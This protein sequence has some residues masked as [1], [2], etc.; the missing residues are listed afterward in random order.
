M[1]FSFRFALAALAAFSLLAVAPA[2]AAPKKEFKVAWSLYVGWMPWGY[3][4]D[5]GIVKKWADKYGLKIDV[6][7][8]NDYI[9]SINQYTAGS[10]DGVLST[11]MDALAIPSVGGVDTTALI[12]GDYSN[13]NDAIILKDKTKLSDIKGQKVNLVELSVS[14]YAMARAL[15]TVGLT[16]KDVT[17]VN[18]SDADMEAAWKTADVTA[19]VTWNPMVAAILK[20]PHAHSVFDSSSIPGEIQDCLVVNT[21]T[22]A[23]NPDFGKAMVGI[24]FETLALM[25]AEA[26]GTAARTEMAKA[27]G[28]DLAGF[29]GQLKTTKMFW[30]PAEA[31]AFSEGDLVPAMDKVRNFLFTH[32][33]LGDNAPSADVVGIEFADGK[34]VG[35][36]NNVKFRFTDKYVKL[37]AEGKL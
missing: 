2:E 36:K 9:E 25:K 15:E 1:K 7:Q 28:T 5:H 22:L 13:G 27:S 19:M 18:T 37:A 23:D 4:Q 16:E 8:F 24:W 3:A 30:T 26:T 6:V 11:N 17:V 29:D 35:D 14:H 20:D 32:G 31:V 33:L 10:L 34:I 21:K 12:A